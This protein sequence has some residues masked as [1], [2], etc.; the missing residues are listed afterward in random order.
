MLEERCYY[1]QNWRKDVVAILTGS[2]ELVEQVRYSSYGM[3]YG[4]PAGDTDSD[5]DYDGA[6][7]TAITGA[8]DVRKDANLDGLVNVFDVTHASNIAG[9]GGTVTTGRDVLGS[10]A[11]ANRFGYGAYLRD[12]AVPQWHV[13]NRVF[14]S[15]LGRWLTRD[16]M[17]YADGYN[18]YTY[19]QSRPVQYVDALGLD[20]SDVR[21]KED[22]KDTKDKKE[23]RDYHKRRGAYYD[24]TLKCGFKQY[25][26]DHT[27]RRSGWTHNIN[28][29]MNGMNKAACCVDKFMIS[30]HHVPGVGVYADRAIDACPSDVF[31]DRIKPC[32]GARI[33]LEVCNGRS[34][35]ERVANN[36][37]HVI[38]EIE[39]TDGT[40]QHVPIDWWIW[41]SH[42][43]D[44]EID[45]GHGD[46]YII[47]N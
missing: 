22:G 12:P 16:P 18:L 3:P 41:P 36:H 23:T 26:T 43:F 27:I 8:Y 46:D 38:F 31:S 35:A 21:E 1:A 47:F 11:N 45:G 15:D 28:G 39:F 40:N 24:Y 34:I 14:R 32:H 9:G 4:L 2:G 44:F 33:N 37:P 6:D 19:S 5:G 42:G 20:S 30:T 10:P 17:L 25:G 13:R 7:A 29:L